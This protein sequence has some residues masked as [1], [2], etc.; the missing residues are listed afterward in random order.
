[1]ISLLLILSAPSGPPQ[2]FRV[3][4]I[5]STSI[6]LTWTAPLPEE[7][8]GVITSYRITVTEVE[9]G[10]VLQRTTSGSDSLIIISS[11]RP[12]FTYRCAI[13]AYTIALGSETTAEVTTLQEGQYI[14]YNYYYCLQYTHSF[15]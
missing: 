4:A 13:A 8:N 12:H 15:Y 11:L 10:Q 1:M 5:S 6:R 7:Q 2:S 9:S 14:Q 3:V